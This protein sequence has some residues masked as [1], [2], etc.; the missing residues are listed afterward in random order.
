MTILEVQTIRQRRARIRFRAAE[1]AMN[2]G[3]AAAREASEIRLH[4][5]GDTISDFDHNL[6][7]WTEAHEFAYRC[8]AAAARLEHDATRILLGGAR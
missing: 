7:Q 4:V 2:L 5:C 3:I 1:R 6:R 8:H